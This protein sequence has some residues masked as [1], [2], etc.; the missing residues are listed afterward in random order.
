MWPHYES[1]WLIQLVYGW[2]NSSLF[3]SMNSHYPNSLGVEF[4]SK[5]EKNNNKKKKKK[6][7]KN[8]FYNK[9][10]PIKWFLEMVWQLQTKF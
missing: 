7:N 9:V 4:T 1:L 6:K 2:F 10:A 3:L 5:K 8:I